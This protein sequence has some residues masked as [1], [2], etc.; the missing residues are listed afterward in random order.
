MLM[1]ITVGAIVLANVDNRD[2]VV[3]RANRHEFQDICRR[4]IKSVK[5]ERPTMSEPQIRGEDRA[6]NAGI[7]VYLHFSYRQGGLFC[8]KWGWYR[9]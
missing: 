7:P 1:N 3:E 5:M 8:G 9:I 6:S 2:T 4:N